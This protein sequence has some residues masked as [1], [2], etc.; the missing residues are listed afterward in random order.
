[1]EEGTKILIVRINCCRDCPFITDKKVKEENSL[2]YCYSLHPFC[3]KTGTDLFTGCEAIPIPN[4]CP[5]PDP[6]WAT[7]TRK[8]FE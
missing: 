1:M 6:T 5:L 2:V 8:D 4:N 3:S 7:V